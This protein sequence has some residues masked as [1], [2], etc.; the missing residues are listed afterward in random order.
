MTLSKN[1]QWM[2]KIEIPAFGML[3]SCVTETGRYCAVKGEM[4]IREDA[5][6]T[7]YESSPIVEMTILLRGTLGFA[8]FVRAWVMDW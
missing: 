7:L 4:V 1:L 3:L 8:I 5:E 2:L 6:Y